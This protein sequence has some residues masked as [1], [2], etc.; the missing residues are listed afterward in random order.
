MIARNALTL[1]VGLAVAALTMPGCSSYAH[2][3]GTMP[4]GLVKMEHAKPM[5]GGTYMDFDP[6]SVELEVIAPEGPS[7]I[8]AQYM[9]IATVRDADGKPL[10][11]RRVEWIIGEG[12]VGAILEVDESGCRCTRGNK[13]TSTWAVSHTNHFQH[14]LTRGDDDP[15]N[16]IV[17]GKGQTWCVITSANPGTTYLTVYAPAIYNWDQ[18][19]VYVKKVWAERQVAPTPPQ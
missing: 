4:G 8:G 18:R 14:T 7:P 5:E 6:A 2:K 16:D 10:P 9:L 3:C 19:V 17:I 11:S 1:V 13:V 15:E 12:S